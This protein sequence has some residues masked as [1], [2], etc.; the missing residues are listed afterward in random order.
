M[1]QNCKLHGPTAKH[2][3][4]SGNSFESY[5]N[6]LDYESNTF[7]Q[8]FYRKNIEFVSHV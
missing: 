8:R 6:D 5:L 4:R 1:H 7:L 3:S 2:N